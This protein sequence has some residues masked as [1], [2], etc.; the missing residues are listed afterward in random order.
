[1]EKLLKF[2]DAKITS[3]KFDE[4]P[5]KA[6]KVINQWVKTKTNKKITNIITA[7]ELNKDTL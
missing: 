2:Y 1:M 5:E 4:S 7:S 6:A 3:L